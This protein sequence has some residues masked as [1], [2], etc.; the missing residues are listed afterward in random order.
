MGAA[1][2]TA[3]DTDAAKTEEARQLGASAFLLYKDF[4]DPGAAAAAGAP[5]CFD[6]IINT[7]PVMLDTAVLMRALMPAGKLVQIGL[8]GGT[9]VMEAR[10]YS[11]TQ[12]SKPAPAA[13]VIA[14]QGADRPSHRRKALVEA[15][16]A[17]HSSACAPGHGGRP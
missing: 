15:R 1:S 9:P 8:P 3:I 10:H 4:A 16:G 17:L 5:R 11:P 14:R 6:L 12:T 7:A 13:P 2:V